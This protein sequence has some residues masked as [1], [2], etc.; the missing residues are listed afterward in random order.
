MSIDLLIGNYFRK[1]PKINSGLLSF[2]VSLFSTLTLRTLMVSVE[3]SGNDRHWEWLLV[4]I[5][6]GDTN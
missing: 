3:I 1:I 5:K 2:S 6:V 4:N